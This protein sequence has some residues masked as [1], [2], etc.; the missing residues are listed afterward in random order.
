[1]SVRCILK[2]VIQVLIYDRLVICI[3][4]ISIFFIL[5]PQRSY[6]QEASKIVEAS[7]NLQQQNTLIENHN[8]QYATDSIPPAISQSV[9]K[10]TKKKRF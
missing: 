3:L 2:K 10:I 1:M 9:R 8:K 4:S 5:N 6:S 7:S